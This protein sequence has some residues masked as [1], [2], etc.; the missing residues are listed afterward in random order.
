MTARLPRAPTQTPRC[1]RMS[2]PTIQP[3]Q[4]LYVVVGT[5]VRLAQSTQLKCH[6]LRGGNWNPGLRN[7][8]TL[9][10]TYVFCKVKSHRPQA[11]ASTLD[12]FTAHLL[13]LQCSQRLTVAVAGGP[14]SSCEHRHPQVRC[15]AHSLWQLVIGVVLWCCMS[16]GAVSMH[17]F[18][19]GPRAHPTT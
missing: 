1:R 19:L 17:A 2:W 7:L 16:S 15:S 4:P 8:Q 13:P 10:P 11:A 9:E 3:L 12:L 6:S 18:A 5:L 14:W